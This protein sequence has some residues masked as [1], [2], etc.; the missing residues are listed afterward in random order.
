M[1]ELRFMCWD[2]GNMIVDRGRGALKVTG[3][4]GGP[5]KIT[6]CV[7]YCNN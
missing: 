7:K 2:L 4:G 6:N 3:G 1:G 5:W